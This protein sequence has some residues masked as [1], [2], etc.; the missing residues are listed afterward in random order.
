MR[1]TSRVINYVIKKD[2]VYSARKDTYEITKANKVLNWFIKILLRKNYIKPYEHGEIAYN[3][4]EIKFDKINELIRELF[5][6]I[7]YTTEKEPRTVVMGYD[8]M[9]QLECEMYQEMRFNMPLE[10]NGNKGRKIFGLDIILNPR[11]D[12]LF[13]I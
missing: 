11:I 6:E 4:V 13:L 7:Y 9:R 10:L 8:K 3:R 2:M 12:G 5:D 1:E